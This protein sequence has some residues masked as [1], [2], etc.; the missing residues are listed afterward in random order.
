MAK[1]ALF[2][3]LV[4][5]E[6]DQQLETGYVGQ[7]AVYVIDDAGFK[8]HI[9]A[10]AIDRPLLKLF[11]EQIQQNKDIAVPQALR[12]LGQDDLFTKAAVDAQID[13]IDIDQI[14]AAGI[15]LQAREMMGMMGFRIIVDY[16]GE[17]IDLKQPNVPD[18]FD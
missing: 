3:G 12:M 7:D 14:L 5:D 13:D 16:H 17:I 11:V 18:D 2:A 15:P 8:R 10:E 1:H 6:Y 4:Y 9:D